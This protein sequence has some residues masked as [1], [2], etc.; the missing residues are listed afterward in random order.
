MELSADTTMMYLIRH[1]ATSANEQQPYI[2]Q[3]CSVDLS[4]S[5]TGREQ[6]ADVARLLC[7]HRLARVYSSRLLRARETATMIAQPHGL[8]VETLEGIEECDVGAWERLDW[9]T[10]RTRFPD[11]YQRFQD[12]PYETPY[13]RGESYRNVFDR[14]WPVL[15]RL[16]EQH[17][18]ETIAVVSHNV[19]NRVIVAELLG[20]ERRKAK[21]IRQVNGGVNVVRYRQGRASLLSLNT[22]FHLRNFIAD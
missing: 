15:M 11:E 2:L 19:V 1:G 13:L 17:R 5:P 7:D 16:L 10:I 3:G 14:A 4:L 8:T 6:A 12:E 22:L 20:L 18:G 9:E 21:E